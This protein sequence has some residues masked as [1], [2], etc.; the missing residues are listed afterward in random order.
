[1]VNDDENNV[2][3]RRYKLYLK[4]GLDVDIPQRTQ[5]KRKNEERV[6]YNQ[7]RMNPFQEHDIQMVEEL[8][9]NRMEVENRENGGDIFDVEQHEDV[10]EQAQENNR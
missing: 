7:L 3:P 10:N 1:M 9:D 2:Q 5:W 8:Q 6:E 4:R